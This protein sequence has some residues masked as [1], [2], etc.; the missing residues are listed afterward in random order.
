MR[1]IPRPRRV[2]RLTRPVPP[3]PAAQLV[4]EPSVRGRQCTQLLVPIAGI[5]AILFAI[6]LARDAV[7]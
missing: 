5:V 4:E 1:R 2:G 3:R 7:A 6:Y